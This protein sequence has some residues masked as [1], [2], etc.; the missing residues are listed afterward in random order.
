MEKICSKCGV[1]KAIDG[2]GFARPRVRRSNC[3][4]CQVIY[5]REY[6]KKN[7]SKAR[8]WAINR[9]EKN[10]TYRANNR[11][12]RN[13]YLKMWGKRNPKKKRGQKY[14]HRYGID[15]EDYNDILKKQKDRCAICGT[16]ELNR[17]NAK[18][19]AVDHCHK[20]GVVRGLLCYSCNALLGKAKDNIDIFLSAIKYLSRIQLK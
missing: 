12:K 17:K 6:R 3:K 14:R 7:K 5:N 8:Q 15:I 11:E 20:T 1:K 9:I 16:K 4:K 10:K 18:F 2:F 13:A 19:F